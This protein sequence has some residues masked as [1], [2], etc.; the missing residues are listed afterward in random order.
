MAE[1][2]NGG[3][4]V[5]VTNSQPA[6]M[7]FSA[8]EIYEEDLSM[9]EVELENHP[10]EL[11]SRIYFGNTGCREG[12]TVASEDC[13]SGDCGE[14]KR[15]TWTKWEQDI[16]K[17]EPF[18]YPYNPRVVETQVGDESNTKRTTIAYL[19]PEVVAEGDNLTQY[20]LAAE[21]NVFNTQS[22]VIKKSTTEYNLNSA[23]TSRRIIG[24]PSKSEAWGWDD[25]MSDLAYVSK[26]TFAYDEGDFSDS[27]LSQTIS[28]VQHCTTAST[29]SV[30]VCPTG[31]GSTFITGR[32]NP[33]PNKNQPSC[34][35]DAVDK[36]RR[37]AS[38]PPLMRAS[39]ISKKYDA[40]FRA[41]VQIIT[42]RILIGRQ[43]N[44]GLSR[45]NS[46]YKD[47]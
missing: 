28:P 42:K 41:C 27:S 7:T 2:F 38:A 36:P 33:K 24:L 47:S 21:V 34:L 23:Y 3:A 22:N 26:V 30:Q 45:K 15:W 39:R 14:R 10:N 12:L 18:D 44:F 40:R 19:Q 5:V 8:G 9:V 29:P 25:A 31:Y 4:E 13:V 1:N 16:L 46:K 20:G 37:I 6:P 35:P 17:G 11:Y 43:K 32:G